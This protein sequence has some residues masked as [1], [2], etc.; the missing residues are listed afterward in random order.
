M[1][2][3]YSETLPARQELCMVSGP[4]R[5]SSRSTPAIR[6]SEPSGSQVPSVLT[7][8]KQSGCHPRLTFPALSRALA[9]SEAYITSHDRLAGFLRSLIAPS[10]PPRSDLSLR[11]GQIVP[12]LFRFADTICV[13]AG[14]A[15]S[16]DQRRVSGRPTGLEPRMTGPSMGI[17][18]WL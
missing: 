7:C 16:Y 13:G 5:N 3:T 17:V 6:C 12:F 18:G 15:P 14:V 1:P 9:C 10:L 2:A 4:P 11:T 8:R